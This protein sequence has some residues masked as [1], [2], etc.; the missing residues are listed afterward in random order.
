MTTEDAAAGLQI[1]AAGARAIGAQRIRD[2]YTG[3]LNVLP[4]EALHAPDKVT[5]A[6][7]TS[8]LPPATLCLGRNEELSQL[9]RVLTGRGE[10]AITQSGAVHGLGGIGKSTLALRY[11]H[12]H[13][14]DYTLIW[15]INAASPDEIETSVTELTKALAPDW[16]ASVERGAQ[17]SWAKQW[18]AWNRGWL[19]IYDNVEDPDDLFPYTGALHQ[20]H[21]L[22]TSRRTTGWPDSTATLPLGNLDLDDATTLLCQLVLKEAAPTPQQKLNARALVADLGCLPL[23]VKQAGAYLAQ[24][25]G[26]SLDAY[27]RRLGTKLFRTAHGIDAERTIA[28][29]W[30]VTLQVLEDEYPLAVE[31]LHTA[32]WLAPDDIPHTLLTPADA[33][34]DDIAEAIGTLAAYSMV[35]DTGTAV[36]IHRLVQTVLRAT[37]LADN[38]QP[39]RH[40]QGRGRA[41]QAVLYHLT[42][43]PGQN[44]ADSQWDSQI[45]HLVTLAATTPP[46]HHNARLTNAYA[47][48]ANRLH[49]QG[50][51]ARTIPLME[52]TLAQREQI[53]GD[54]HPQTLT[55]RN[56]LAYA[57]Q[58]AG[59]MRRAIPLYE[60]TLAQYEQ[61]LG[62]THP[63]T[64]TTR[65]NLAGA[66]QSAGDVGRPIPLLEATLAQ[67]EQVLGDTHPETLRSRNNLA[68]AYE[69]AGDLDRATPLFEATLA[70]YE[71][72]LGDTHPETLASRNNLAYAYESA[73]DMRRAIPL[74]EA[75]LAQYEQVLGDTHPE[76]L[77]SRNNLA[78]AYES[79]GD[80]RRAIP[81]YEA[82]LA[83]REQVLGDTH[84]STLT[85]RNNLAHAYQSAGDLDRA[86]PL[87]EATLA[88][89]EQV[90]DE[91]HPKT[92]TSRNNLASAYESAGDLRRAIPLYEATLA[93]CEQVL[94]DTHPETLT[95][96]NNLAYARSAAAAVQ[97]SDT[98][99]P[100]TAHD[101]HP[102]TS[103]QPVSPSP[104]DLCRATDQ[105]GFD[106]HG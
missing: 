57:Y 49:H 51:T 32:A 81:L 75:T 2:A 6:P 25:R 56:N 44:T 70:Q 93:Q 83:Q 15:W 76:T 46:G 47:T 63:S 55:T 98:A 11:A 103:E 96:R 79:A 65:N 28:R 21:H 64:L 43:L 89:C 23:A 41:E 94:G 91:T 17:V 18:L 77:T 95:S 86:I 33:D 48:A 38:T 66:Y 69:S 26:V 85:S 34:P 39:P 106:I 80:L 104:T 82:T 12:Y 8:N 99:A 30:N 72:I 19:L 29:V 73:G 53:L 88:Q 31:V 50:H 61:V 37:Q 13:R 67:C 90:L 78:S 105:K 24:N 60:A 20:G 35:T 59:D 7:G 74:Y 16:A 3:D 22:A 4:T 97:P 84:P 71:Q 100:A 62:D 45:P 102:G 42:A 87:Y 92:L 58:S 54:I 36:T 10:G 52:A 27:R 40:L 101:H 9:R 68:S 5:A 14:S 1:E